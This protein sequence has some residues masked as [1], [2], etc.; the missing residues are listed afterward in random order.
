[1]L[2]LS[3]VFSAQ[4]AFAPAEPALRDE[5][6]SRLDSMAAAAIAGDGPAYLDHIAQDEREFLIEER[7]WAKDIARIAPDVLHYELLS[8]PE[9]VSET[10]ATARV[11]II[12]N[13]PNWEGEDRVLEVPTRFVRGDDGLWD[14]AGRAWRELDAD[15]LR[16]LYVNG[17]GH[18]ARAAVELWP[19]IKAHVEEGFEMSLDHPQVVK[20]Y[21]TMQELQFSIFP[22]YAEPL[23][24]WNEPG[25]SIKLVGGDQGPEYL[26]AVLAHEYGHALTFAMGGPDVETAIERAHAMPWWLLEGVAELAASKFSRDFSATKAAVNEWHRRGELPEWGRITDFYTT[27]PSDYGYV[28]TQGMHFAAYISDRFGRSPRNAWL[29]SMM[30]GKTIDAA[31]REVLGVGF[32]ELDADWRASVARD[33]AGG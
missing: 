32:D 18:I 10:E 17:S 14:Y 21:P 6:R 2:T 7:A 1:M 33:A 19:E 3:L 4:V 8:P 30:S 29:R 26:R 31:S 25:E 13:T 24:G 15:G 20:V 12:W 28:Y 16:V 11:R 9:L 5:I 27:A 23:G 22:A